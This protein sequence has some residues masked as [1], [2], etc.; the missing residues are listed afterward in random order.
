MAWTRT[1]ERAEQGPQQ[2]RT[3]RRTRDGGP[4]VFCHY[5]AIQQDGY[6]ALDEGA[7][8]TYDVV[9]GIKGPQADNVVVLGDERSI[10]KRKPIRRPR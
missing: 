1:S 7:A 8:V 9:Q 5:S 4:D 6:K 10:P 2:M 3:F